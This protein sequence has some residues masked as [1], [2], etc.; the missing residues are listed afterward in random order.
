MLAAGYLR[1]YTVVRFLEFCGQ[2]FGTQMCAINLP[3]L[4]CMTNTQL[5]AELLV[6]VYQDQV[7]CKNKVQY[8]QPC[9]VFHRAST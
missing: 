2:Y 7:S 6:L 9:T 8:K 5:R 4:M 3:T 1:T